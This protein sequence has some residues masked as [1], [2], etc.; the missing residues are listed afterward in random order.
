MIEGAHRRRALNFL[1]MLKRCVGVLAVVLVLVGVV[2]GAQSSQRWYVVRSQHLWVAL[3]SDVPVSFVDGARSLDDV[4]QAFEAQARALESDFQKVERW[5]QVDYPT[6][7]LGRVP[8]LVYPDLEAYQV[9]ASCLICAAHVGRPLNQPFGSGA[10]LLGFGAHLNL[11]SRTSTVL[12][13]F[14][15][16]VDFAALPNAPAPMWY[17]GLASYVGNRLLG[18][19]GKPFID[20]LPQYLKQYQQTHGLSLRDYLTR[21]GYGRWTYNLGTNLIDLLVRREGVE[22][23]LSFYRALQRPDLAE[24]DR[25]F[26]RFYGLGL[27]EIEALWQAQLEHTVVTEEGALSYRFKFDQI[28]VRWIYLRPLLK[29]PQRLERAYSNLWQGGKFNAQ[30]AQ[31]MRDYL[32]DPDNLMFDA[33]RIQT[34]LQNT[35]QLRGYV[36]TYAE[37]PAQQRALDRQLQALETLCVAKTYACGLRYFNLI[38]DFV[39]WT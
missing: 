20:I 6:G 33:Q 25:L 17:E 32:N 18:A 5:L 36:A 9:A 34:L 2:W 13:E 1:N 35:Q 21:P 11:T 37:N 28:V 31:F 26:R 23:F 14:V 39:R 15:H 38:H 29:D 4:R 12:H 10:S 24:Y 16:I 27:D 22:R 7:V 30:E 3:R 8:V 19:A